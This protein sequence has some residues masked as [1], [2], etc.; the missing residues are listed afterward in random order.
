MYIEPMTRLY[1]E[2]HP[3]ITF[4]FK[5]VYE[6]TSMKMGEAYSKCQHLAGTPLQPRV[7]ETL[8]R[9]Y[10]VKGAAATTAIEGN[11]LSEEEV[12]QIIHHGKRLPPSQQYLEQEIRNILQVLNNIQSTAWGSDESLTVSPQW[13]KDQNCQILQ[14]LDLQDHVIPGE[15]T[16]ST[17]LVGTYRGAPP[18]DVSYLIDRLCSW[19]NDR[20]RQ[21]QDDEIPHEL[22][23]YNAVTTAIIAHL[24]IAWIHPFGDGN[25]RTAR[26]LECAIL[27]NSGLVPWVSSNLLSD[28]YNR[29]RSRYYDKL[30]A[31]SRLNDI[32]GFIHYALDGFVDLLC[33]QI[34]EV[35]SMQRKVEW[36][37][38]IHEVFRSETHGD[39]SHRR[40]TLVLSLPEGKKTARSQIKRLNVELAGLYSTRSEKTISHDLNKLKQ[41]QLI[42]GDVRTGYSPRIHIMDAFLPENIHP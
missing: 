34:T 35:Q 9:T 26:A 37:N 18:E 31:S 38:Y 27:T 30:S 10:L 28:F 12:D 6:V 42:D 25:G 33:E 29:T 11:S 4:T 23:F 21:G 1:E 40:R 3:W 32:Q 14:N 41:L 17:L 7:A 22:R 36:V 24:Y 15:Y 8:A 19:I 16:T 20:I 13:L 2:T 39:T 5:P